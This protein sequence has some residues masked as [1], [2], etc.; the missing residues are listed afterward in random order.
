M[1]VRTI[2]AITQVENEI[3]Q[4]S[5]AFL[6]PNF[7][8]FINTAMNV[9]NTGL[10]YINIEYNFNFTATNDIPDYGQVLLTFPN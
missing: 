1:L 3:I 2:N 6:T 5:A 4:C 7:N 9:S 8:A 10:N